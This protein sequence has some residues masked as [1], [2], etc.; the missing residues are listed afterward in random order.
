MDFWTA[1]LRGKDGWLQPLKLYATYSGVKQL[2]GKTRTLW[3]RSAL[4]EVLCGYHS[5]PL[6]SEL[7]WFIHSPGR[8]VSS[9]PANRPAKQIESRAY[10]WGGSAYWGY[11]HVSTLNYENLLPGG[12]CFRP[13]SFHFFTTQSRPTYRNV[14]F[15]LAVSLVI[16]KTFPKTAANALQSFNLGDFQESAYRGVF[17]LK[18]RFL[19]NIWFSGV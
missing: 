8:T 9:N 10:P 6:C 7:L 17:W 3:N 11:V 12:V 1:F 16:S 18:F 13:N 14:L 4:L 2:S 5:Q 15:V 19:G